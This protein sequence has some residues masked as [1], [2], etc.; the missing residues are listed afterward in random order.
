MKIGILGSGDVAKTL[1]NGFIKHGYQVMMGTSNPTKLDEWKSNAG[2]NGSVGSFS[3][4]AVFGDLIVLAIKGSAAK[5]G[6]NIAGVAHLSG[7]TIIDTTNPIADL[8]P[9]NGVIK[10]FTNLDKSWM[11]ELQESFPQANFVKAF[12]MI[13]NH[14]M[15]NPDFGGVKPSMFICGNNS[16]AKAEVTAILDKF[17]FETEDFGFAES[18][19]A[20]EP[21]C[22]LWCIPGMLE[23]K[24][25]HA[26]KLLKI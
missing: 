6:L 13:G 25:M 15:V 3:D 22:I 10:F 18:A 17:G 7:K 20:I 26:F 24:W 12:S 14:F 4:S 2:T 8:P 21:L 19:R 11:E 23:N 16:N 1:A 9:E 5:E